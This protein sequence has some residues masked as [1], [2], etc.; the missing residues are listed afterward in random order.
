L[1]AFFGSL[2]AT[3]GGF[4]VSVG[5]AIKNAFFDAVS[6]VK[7][8]IDD[9]WAKITSVF[10]GIIAA[11]QRVAAAVRSA[12]SGSSDASAGS[13]A[14]GFAGGGAVRGP[15]TS[16]SDSI[17]ALL[18]DGEF[19]LNARAVAH[20]GLGRLHAMNNLRMPQ[21]NSGGLVEA[22]SAVGPGRI[23]RFA[24]GGLARAGAGGGSGTPV[25]LHFPGGM[26]GPV[27]ADRDV[28]KALRR[29][30]V[31]GKTNSAGKKPGFV[32]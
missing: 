28:M 31:S 15:G 16:R 32:S 4:F 13:G 20:W 8:F 12:V 24:D 23:P 1:L 11:A 25:N 14:P 22:L 19:V 17:L 18:S 6:A 3:V 9:L 27:M 5:E 10:A 2:P 29:M 30:A 21:F 7:G 26:V